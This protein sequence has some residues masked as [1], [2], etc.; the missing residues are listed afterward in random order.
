[1]KLQSANRIVVH[2]LVKVMKSTARLTADRD[3]SQFPGLT[4]QRHLALQAE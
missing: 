2:P 3:Q 1:M 4:T